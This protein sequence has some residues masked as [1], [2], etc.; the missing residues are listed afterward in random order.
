MTSNLAG[1]TEWTP[2]RSINSLAFEY[3]HIVADD[4]VASMYRDTGGCLVRAPIMS[5]PVYE[6]PAILRRSLEKLS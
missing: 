3:V 4:S 2:I 6:L 1:P 5:E